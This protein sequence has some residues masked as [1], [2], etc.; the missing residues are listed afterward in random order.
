M[1]HP[2]R[3]RSGERRQD[4]RITLTLPLEEGTL[5]HRQL[6]GVANYYKFK[7]FGSMVDKIFQ[8]YQTQFLNQHK[9]GAAVLSSYLKPAVFYKN[10]SKEKAAHLAEPPETI[11]GDDNRIRVTLPVTLAS[12][13]HYNIEALAAYNKV[14]RATFLL[15]LTT[16]F[17]HR[18]MRNEGNDEILN[19]AEPRTEAVE[20][21]IA[22]LQELFSLEPPE[23]EK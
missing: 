23:E 22:Q 14:D 6:Q 16:S 3:L 1:A 9:Y 4:V 11:P 10:A 17:V 18:A 20:K 7:D 8:E 13:T 15:N 12:Q 5:G 21:E 19:A 2:D